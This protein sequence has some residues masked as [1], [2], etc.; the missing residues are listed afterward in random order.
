MGRTERTEPLRR[1]R[2]L[3]GDLWP[4]GLAYMTHKQTAA[5]K[6]ERQLGGGGPVRVRMFRDVPAARRRSY[7]NRRGRLAPGSVQRARR[8]R[9]AR[10]RLCCSY[11]RLTLRFQ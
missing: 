4:Q 7:S 2:Q 8:R 5:G 10:A 6:K 3:N 9:C 1:T 11:L